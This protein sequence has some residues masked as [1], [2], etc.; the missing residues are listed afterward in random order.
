MG[1]FEFMMPMLLIKDIE[2]IK[3]IAVKDFDYF[4]DH[5]TII[6]ENTDPLFG[7][8]LFS[9]KGNQTI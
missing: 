6:D 1:R 3:K 4:T 5:R 7:R 8:N 9:M 2:L